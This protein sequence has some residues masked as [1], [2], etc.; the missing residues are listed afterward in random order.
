MPRTLES[1][2]EPAGDDAAGAVRR[3]LAAARSRQ[4]EDPAGVMA[5]AIR[6]HQVGSLLGDPALCARALTLQAAAAIHRGDLSAALE[7][8]IEA[9]QHG[10]PGDEARVE[11]AAVKARLSLFT[12]SYSEALDHARTAVSLA[13]ASGDRALRI[14]ARRTTCMVFGTL[15]VRDLRERIDH[16]LELTID[17]G[18]AWEEA[19]SRNDLACFL[20]ESGEIAGAEREIDRALELAAELGD[21]GRF[22]RAVVHSTRAD[23]G[24]AAGRPADALADADRSLALLIE[25]DEPDPYVLAATIRASVQ[26]RA[27]L[28]RI[29]EA[30]Q[31]GE[32]ALTRLGDRVPQ[33]RSLILSTLAAALREAGQLQDAYEA[34]SRAAE[35]ERQGLQELSELQL[36]LERALVEVNTAREQSD[37]LEARNRELALAHAELERRTGQL[38]ELQ[39]QLRDQAERDWLT[40]VHNRRRLARELERLS[41]DHLAL[42][43]SIALLDLDHFK[44]INDCF[45]HAVGDQVLVRAAGLLCDALRDTDTVIRS[46]GEEFL[47]LMPHTDARAAAACCARIRAKIYA[48]PWERIAP[49]LAVTTSIGLASTREHGDL[50]PLVR[51]ADQRLYEAKHGGRNRIVDGSGGRGG[52]APASA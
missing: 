5:D 27:A 3:A 2:T 15:G 9:E 50:E 47:V 1:T 19:I 40:G 39:E 13:D 8:T 20:C 11:L 38:E 26:A 33:T 51:L 43:F 16:L 46:G 21:E 14:H 12:G 45:G 31:L 6:Y 29:D 41:Y 28:G 34:L 42:P 44:S 49:G 52:P 4:L 18:D 30:R 22:A 23:I 36:R 25:G 7:R 48:E 10:A 24:L 17:A 35:L 32:D 37:A